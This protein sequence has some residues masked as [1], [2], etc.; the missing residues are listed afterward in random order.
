MNITEI[1]RTFSH[2]NI[3]LTEGKLS[4]LYI[5]T[6]PDG[7][8]QSFSNTEDDGLCF[9]SSKYV[10]ESLI[11]FSDSVHFNVFR[12]GEVRIDFNSEAFNAGVKY[13]AFPT[14]FKDRVNEFDIDD[15]MVY[16]SDAFK[17]Y[18]ELLEGYDLTNKNDQEL[19]FADFL[20]WI[21]DNKDQPETL[22]EDDLLSW[23]SLTES[24][25]SLFDKLGYGEYEVTEPSSEDM[26]G[27]VEIWFTTQ[28]YL[29]IVLSDE[30][31]NALLNAIHQSSSVD[32]DIVNH[33]GE[34]D[35]YFTICFYH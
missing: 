14:L 31:K 7:S 3:L 17:K 23:D 15:E 25:L 26:N 4:V 21:N 13:L 12:D 27:F 20:S 6:N 11:K 28:T 16:E 2:G 1:Q 30:V 5:K 10:L 33:I 9:S 18:A 35:T 19:V 32:F 29:R 22:S 34:H 8:Q 24:T